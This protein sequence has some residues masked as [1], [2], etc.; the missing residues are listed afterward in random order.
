VFI[1]Y[2]EAEEMAEVVEIVVVE[3]EVGGKGW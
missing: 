2:G 3:V 1:V